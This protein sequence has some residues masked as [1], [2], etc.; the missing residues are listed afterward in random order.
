MSEGKQS[1]RFFTDLAFRAKV[2]EDVLDIAYQE[3]ARKLDSQMEGYRH[4]EQT[5]S[6]LL[7][8]IFAGFISL[9][10]AVVALYCSGGV[11]IPF[12]MAVYALTALIVPASVLVR[13]IHFGQSQYTPGAEPRHS[14]NPDYC[15]WLLDYDIEHQTKEFKFARLQSMQT[16]M[17]YNSSRNL[18]RIRCYRLAVRILGTE[19]LGAVALFLCL[20]LF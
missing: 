2:D 1:E 8:W 14:L 9:A 12:I 3:A 7:G 4:I 10:A 19:A 5:S 17:D 15:Q 20:I 6:V 16:S 11:T 13:G 18:R